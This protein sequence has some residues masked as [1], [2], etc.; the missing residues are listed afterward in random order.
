MER[1]RQ[2]EWE[3][4]RSQEL[5]QQ[6]QRS[7]ENVLRLKAR[8]QTLTI[9]LNSL[10]EQVK[11]LSQKICNTRVGVS[12]V[13]TTIDGMRTTR[14]T[15]MQELSQLKTK[16]KEQNAR[17]IALTQEKSKLEAKNKNFNQSDHEDLA[18]TQVA[19]D[20]KEVLIKQLKVT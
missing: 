12:N 20:N 9:E 16:L 13:K 19:F 14:D 3:K 1:Q 2:L 11:D 5:Q 10:T 15:H 8:N 18:Q 17:L 7:Q 6:R 4:Q